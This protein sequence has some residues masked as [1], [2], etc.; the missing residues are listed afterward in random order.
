MKDPTHPSPPGT[1]GPDVRATESVAGEEDPGASIDL[2][3]PTGGTNPVSPGDEA[4][5]GTPGTGEAPC[6]RCG[7][8]GRIGDQRCPACEGTG[9]VVRGIGG[10]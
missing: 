6:P 8:S 7:G 5:P 3:V 10:A 4:V 2:A 9:K 1:T